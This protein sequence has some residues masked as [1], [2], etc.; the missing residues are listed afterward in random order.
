MNRLIKKKIIRDSTFLVT[1]GYLNQFFFF[2][3]GFIIARLLDPTLFGYL[4]GTR[5]VQQFTSQMHFGI[6]HGMTREFSHYKGANDIVSFQKTKNNGISIITIFSVFIVFGI[7]IYTFLVQDRYSPYTIWGI[8]LFAI[9]A[10]IQQSINI[11]HALLRVDY[12]FNEISISQIV[13]GFS[14]LILA[15]ALVLS[16]GFYGA[17]FSFLVANLLSFNYLVKRIK[18]DFTFDLDKKRIKNLL[19]IGAPIS[20]FYFNEE[21]LNGIDKLIIINFL[22]IKE[23]GYYSIA[24]PFFTLIRNI[25][26]S[27]S[28]II[29]PKML[30]AYGSSFNEIK[31]IKKYFNIPSQVISCVVAFAVG[32]LFLSIKYILFYFL[33]R[34]MEAINVVRILSFAIFFSSLGVLALRVLITQKSYKVLF[35]FQCIAIIANFFLNIT[36]IKM[37]Y[38]IKGVAA[39][40]G[41]SYFIYSMLTLQ[42]T[43]AQFYE[44]LRDIW[45]NQLKLFW[46]ILYVGLIIYVLWKIPYFHM[47]VIHK[48]S[49]D[50][51][52]LG[53]NILVY[54]LLVIPL[55]FAINLRKIKEIV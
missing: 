53:I 30:E 24:F 38:G 13:L 55:F 52:Q 15:V 11:C 39:A 47:D 1:V 7:I 8:R 26:Y 14:S 19:L 28:Y 41:V 36:L 20:F 10:F 4:S 22:S 50:M 31:S 21:I 45:V 34:Y 27:I 46:P 43:L 48:F 6:L 23:L 25:P 33:P 29:Y 40:T 9:V 35:V 2:I 12:R 32:M 16:I 3:R 49:V 5:L 37:G 17:I 42:H 54:S 51:F 18:F 44:N